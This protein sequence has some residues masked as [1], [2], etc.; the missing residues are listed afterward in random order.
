MKRKQL[1]YNQM[2]GVGAPAA[3]QNPPPAGAAAPPAAT[4]YKEGDMAKDK[5][6]KP[7]MYKNGQWVYS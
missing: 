6:G 4:Q 5:N 3:G 7:I 1:E 2:F